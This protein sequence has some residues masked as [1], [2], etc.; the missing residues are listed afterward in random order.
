MKPLSALLIQLLGMALTLTGALLPIAALLV[1]RTGDALARWV[2]ER[3]PWCVLLLPIGIFLLL[4]SRGLPLGP[5]EEVGRNER[6]FLRHGDPGM[7]S[8]RAGPAHDVMRRVAR[9]PGLVLFALAL[10]IV[11]SV[12]P[13]SAL[14]L[15]EPGGSEAFQAPGFWCFLF[16]PLGILLLIGTLMRSD[17]PWTS[18]SRLRRLL[19]RH[20]VLRLIGVGLIV[21]SMAG[22][23]TSSLLGPAGDPDDDALEA[24]SK[25]RDD[26]ADTGSGF[27]LSLPELAFRGF[28]LAAGIILLLLSLEPGGIEY[29]S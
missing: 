11:G 20:P 17:E 25:S 16:L 23:C 7:P 19:M 13:I 14:L 15:H 21:M 6:Q 24:G 5:R 12:G 27:G 10:I 22:P 8:E 9:H 28:F 1:P 26:A 3:G 2:V 4:A 29:T 18:S